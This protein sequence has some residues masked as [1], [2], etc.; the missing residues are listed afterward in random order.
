MI[1]SS[2]RNPDR[3][4]FRCSSN[5]QQRCRC[6]IYPSFAQHRKPHPARGPL[7]FRLAK[8]NEDML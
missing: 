8:S 5:L 6:V 7:V 4:I 3:L 2:D 1:Q